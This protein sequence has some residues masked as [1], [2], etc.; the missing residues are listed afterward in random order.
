VDPVW[1]ARTSTDNAA[2]E[3]DKPCEPDALQSSSPR[4]II[5]KADV[6]NDDPAHA[7]VDD[8]ATAPEPQQAKDETTRVFSEH[9]GIFLLINALESG[10]VRDSILASEQEGWAWIWYIG[11]LIGLDPDAA[12]RRFF[13]ARLGLDPESDLR[14][15]EPD[16]L[17]KAELAAVSEVLARRYQHL[18]LWDRTLMD[19]PGVIRLTASHLDVDLPLNA[20][21]TDVRVAGLDRDPGWV[22]WLG[23]LVA[24]HF[25]DNPSGAADGAHE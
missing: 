19:V 9:A 6:R 2:A 20:A 14:G 22:D 1:E 18:G 21:R 24:F 3:R 16:P 11:R 7:P 12:L 10:D 23:R 5:P 13:A 4:E 17:F 15:I 8:T 25:I